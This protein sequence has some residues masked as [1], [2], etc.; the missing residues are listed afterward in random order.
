[1]W[2]YVIGACLCD[3]HAHVQARFRNQCPLPIAA[4]AK[5]SPVDKVCHL[6][7]DPSASTSTLALQAE[8][9]VSDNEIPSRVHFK[10]SWMLVNG[11]VRTVSADSLREDES[12]VSSKVGF[13]TLCTYN[14]L[15]NGSAIFVPGSYNQINASSVA[16]NE[17]VGG[18]PRWRSKD[19]P[20]ALPRDTGYQFVDQNAFRVPKYPFEPAFGALSVMNQD[21]QLNDADLI[22]NRNSLRKLLDFSAG[23]RQDPFR[24]DLH[25]VKET[26]FVSRRE[27]SARLMIRGSTNAGYG[28]S[29]ET[30]FTEPQAGLDHS[31]SH[32]RVIRYKMGSLDCV[33]RF[34]VDACYEERKNFE[35]SPGDVDDVED[36]LTSLTSLAIGRPYSG[37]RGRDETRV[38][39]EGIDIAPSSLAELKTH[40]TTRINKAIPQLWFGRTPYLITGQHIEGSVHSVS[41]DHVEEKL[42][43]WET[44][45]QNALRKL[46]SLLKELKQIVG[47]MEDRTA[48]LMCQWK[49]APLKIFSE[50]RKSEVLPSDIVD[51]HWNE[52]A[53]SKEPRNQ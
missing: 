6:H 46:V 17:D 16:A 42:E 10:M 34:E 12:V 9:T 27:P 19:L 21:V 11:L 25:M 45:H 51:R 38:I 22:V 39:P 47:S 49:G 48:I 37:A 13:E 31:S 26:L 35:S 5:S 3:F 32:H 52:G 1:M 44:T 33:V 41:C 7:A 43:A 4:V 14:W 28:H 2:R 36:V 23:R 20:V 24:I 29:F 53:E 50:K 15:N 40:K 8:L 18:P 30:V